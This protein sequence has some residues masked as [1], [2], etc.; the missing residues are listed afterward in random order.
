MYRLSPRARCSSNVVGVVS[1]VTVVTFIILAILSLKS[2]PTEPIDAQF[3]MPETSFVQVPSLLAE[4]ICTPP[5]V[6]GLYPGTSTITDVRNVLSNDIGAEVFGIDMESLKLFTGE[7]RLPF[8]WKYRYW[9]QNWVLLEN[10]MYFDNGVLER[11]EIMMN[12]PMTMGE[13]LARLGSPSLVLARSDLGLTILLF[14]PKAGLTIG[15]I[16]DEAECTLRSIKEDLV[17]YNL[18]YYLPRLL[19]D[20]LQ[21]YENNTKVINI[22]VWDEWLDGDEPTTCSGAIA[23]IEDVYKS[24]FVSTLFPDTSSTN[25]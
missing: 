5:C 15:V 16:N 19:R 17:V 4:D 23:N 18:D 13:A 21:E 12:H 8:N 7:D 22:L 10:M 20:N 6:F 3:E 25:R 2:S 24:E 9:Q 1:I 11:V 14:Y